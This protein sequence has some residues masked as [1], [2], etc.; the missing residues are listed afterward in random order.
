ML[1]D[2]GGL[3]TTR[4]HFV[5]A[6]E[7]VD[8]LLNAANRV[9]ANLNTPLDNENFARIREDIA[10][11]ESL[12]LKDN[13]TWLRRLALSFARYDSPEYLESMSE[14]HQQVNHTAMKS[15]TKQIFPQSNQI[16]TVDLPR[17][18]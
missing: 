7:R 11:A 3:V 15:L 12:R 14:L 1:L 9:L 18:S 6:P 10:F 4:L 13:N 17:Q 5:T 16:V 8:E 2:Q